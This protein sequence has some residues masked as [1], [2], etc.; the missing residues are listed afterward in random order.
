MMPMPM[1]RKA[2]KMEKV[3]NLS[4]TARVQK[5]LPTR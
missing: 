1:R 5:I 4:R 2:R 3:K